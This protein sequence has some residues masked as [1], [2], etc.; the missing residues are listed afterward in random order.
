[1]PRSSDIDRMF[2]DSH[3]E[4]EI[5]RKSIIEEDVKGWYFDSAGAHAAAHNT[6]IDFYSEHH[7]RSVAFKAI[8]TSFSDNYNQTFEGDKLG[9]NITRQKLNYTGRKRTINLSFDVV[10]ASEKEAEYNLKRLNEL[11]IFCHDDTVKV[12]SS[13]SKGGGDTPSDTTPSNTAH[14]PENQ[15]TA[16]TKPG[17]V[18]VKFLNLICKSPKRD[19]ADGGGLKCQVATLAYDFSTEHTYFKISG[20]TSASAR[21]AKNKNT[22][23]A[24]S[25]VSVTLSLEVEDGE[26]KGKTKRIGPYGRGKFPDKAPDLQVPSGNSESNKDI[27]QSIKKILGN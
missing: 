9:T 8:I 2:Y 18:K 3:S 10:A 4:I 13:D 6:V 26:F 1:M 24:P 14:C 11:A 23:I 12:Q 21:R 16:R 7:K 20:D 15:E 17:T 25:K 19:Y 5:D 22:I 27:R